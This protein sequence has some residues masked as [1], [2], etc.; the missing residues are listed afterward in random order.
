MQPTDRDWR[1]PD[2]CPPSPLW[3]IH[4]TAHAPHHDPHGPVP[5]VGDLAEGHLA[6]WEHAW[7]DLGGE[8]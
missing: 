7:I 1:S 5:S 2:G 4:H 8:G 6:S 3:A